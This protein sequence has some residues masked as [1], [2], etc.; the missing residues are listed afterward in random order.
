MKDEEEVLRTGRLISK[1]MRLLI[2]MAFLTV[3]SGLIAGPLEKLTVLNTK[4]TIIQDFRLPAYCRI[5]ADLFNESP[6]DLSGE[7]RMRQQSG[8]LKL[9]QNGLDH[10]T[11]YLWENLF[12][13]TLK[14]SIEIIWQSDLDETT[15]DTLRFPLNW[16]K[17]FHRDIALNDEWVFS[18]MKRD[19]GGGKP[20]VTV[21][22]PIPAKV[23]VVAQDFRLY[24]VDTLFNEEKF[25]GLERIPCLTE[26][27]AKG[28]FTFVLYVNG[29]R[30][31]ARKIVEPKYKN[32]GEF[33]YGE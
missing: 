33:Y 5:E 2:L 6:A 19:G 15:T 17:A 21:F 26:R 11:I 12:L 4:I 29:V 28:G 31:G 32:P 8:H 25:R 20:Y 24:P 1:T 23:M 3:P 18:E 22:I 27:I 14:K 9:R 13:D 10:I 16:R 7:W 30:I